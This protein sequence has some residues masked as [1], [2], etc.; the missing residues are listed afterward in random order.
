MSELKL[1]PPKRQSPQ[2][3]LKLRAPKRQCLR[4]SELKLRVPKRQI[5][6][7]TAGAYD[8]VRR[9]ASQCRAKR[10]Q[11]PGDSE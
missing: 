10:E 6:P 7:Q 11:W 5:F 2:A 1:R 4:V 3:E 8:S 9:S